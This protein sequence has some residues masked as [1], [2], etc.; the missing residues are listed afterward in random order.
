MN[1]IAKH[2]ENDYLGFSGMIISALRYCL[3]R[4]TY[5][6]SLVTG[7]VSVILSDLQTKDL[8][9]IQRD[10]IEH[11][12][13]SWSVNKDETVDDRGLYK[14]AYGDDCDYITWMKFLK[15]VEDDIASREDNR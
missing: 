15:K 7:F 11:G 13:V 12:R 14:S 8:V 6:P 1:N 2:I 5:M 3:G 9:I 10:L 4:R